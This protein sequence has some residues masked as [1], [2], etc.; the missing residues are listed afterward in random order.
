MKGKE[1]GVINLIMVDLDDSYKKKEF[2]ENVNKYKD[3][4]SSLDLERFKKDVEEIVKINL[5]IWIDVAKINDLK[6]DKVL[7]KEAFEITAGLESV[8]ELIEIPDVGKINITN[9]KGTVIFTDISKSTKFLEKE[10]YTGFVIFNS[11]ISLIKTY[12]R[13]SGGEFLEHTGDG[14]MIFYEE[15]IL[16]TYDE[17]KYLVDHPL[18]MIFNLGYLLQLEAKNNQLLDFDD[19][20]EEIYSLVHVGASYGDVLDVNLGDMRKII[21]DTV[22]EAANNCKE[23]SRTFKLNNKGEFVKLPIK[24]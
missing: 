20:K 12:V 17:C 23:A 15:N 24:I 16:N 21:S 3:L 18:C 13:L 9:N 1:F 6:L 4:I 5:S 10:N 8:N 22:W 2:M 7:I 14:S 19:K 11:Y